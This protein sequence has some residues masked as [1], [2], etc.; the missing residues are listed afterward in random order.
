MRC[1]EY[2][3]LLNELLNKTLT[4]GERRGV[5]AHL[6][7]CEGCRNEFQRLKGL[8]NCREVVSGMF[9]ELRFL[10]VF[11]MY[12]RSHKEQKNR[13]AG[14]PG[15]CRHFKLAVAAVL[16]YL[17]GGPSATVHL[18]PPPKQSR[19]LCRIRQPTMH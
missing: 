11:P 5:E 6:A 12:R 10:P 13:P 17:F 3:P 15:G 2:L 16:L 8:M 18:A 4:P 9:S 19:L 7:V 14:T 1:E